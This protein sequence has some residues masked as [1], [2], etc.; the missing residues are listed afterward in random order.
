MT[1]NQQGPSGGPDLSFR[2]PRDRVFI[3]SD[4]SGDNNTKEGF[5]FKIGLDHNTQKN[6]IQIEAKR[7]NAAYN[8]STLVQSP[9]SAQLGPALTASATGRFIRTNDTAEPNDKPSSL[10]PETP[11]NDFG[12][13]F[14][15]V[16]VVDKLR[17]S[18]VFPG[19]AVS[20]IINTTISQQIGPTTDEVIQNVTH[21][22]GSLAATADVAYTVYA[23]PTNSAPIIFG[24][25]NFLASKFPANQPVIIDFGGSVR[26][27]RNLTHLI[28]LTSVNSLSL[29]TDASNNILT[30]FS[31]SDFK[32][33]GG[34]TDNRMVNAELQ[35]IVNADLKPV[36]AGAFL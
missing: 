8:L 5:R 24:P 10:I 32:T 14:L 19:P 11:F 20:E 17:P 22:T 31:L 6:F 9:N 25:F 13:A 34:I 12:S 36:Y 28:E 23:G 3:Q 33:L 16:P 15:E 21:Q 35:E 7:I 27:H 30:L 18:D 2:N 26:F 29:E 4:E 1:I